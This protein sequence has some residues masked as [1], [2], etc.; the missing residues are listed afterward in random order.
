M[1]SW[2]K[3]F[4][5][6]ILDRGLDYYESKAVSIYS[7]SHDHVEAQVAGS[8]IYDV[9]INFDDGKITSMYC[10]CPYYDNCKHMAATLY[11]I[12]EHPELLKK[13]ED[14]FDMV[15][16]MTSDE[17]RAFLLEETIHNPDLANRLK[18][19]KKMD[20]DEEYYI[21]R[22]NASF[23]SSF[24][25]LKFMDEGFEEL[26]RYGRYDLLFKLSK[27][28]ID[29]INEELR[30]GEFSHLEDIVYRLDDITTQLRDVDEAHE[31]ICDFLEYA[32][33]SSDDYLILDVLTDAMSRNGDMSRLFD[34]HD[35]ELSC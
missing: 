15:L 14:V 30:Y 8:I 9:R 25:I 33:T 24:E 6:K 35:E 1:D 11:Y 23:S 28:L 26:I 34:G 13:Q 32:I 22:L 3:H 17:L 19:F 10:D 2:R 18:L 27:L 21:R 29:H 4:E 20:V 7:S 12:E 5:A 16:A 31:G